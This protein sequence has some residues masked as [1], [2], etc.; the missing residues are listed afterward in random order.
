MFGPINNKNF[1]LR[2]IFSI[3]NNSLVIYLTINLS[4]QQRT[5][6]YVNINLCDFF[7]MRISLF[8]INNTFS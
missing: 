5:F 6:F 3:H 4:T 1:Y 2:H 8:Y 7:C